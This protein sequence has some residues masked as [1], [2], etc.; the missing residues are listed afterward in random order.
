[1]HRLLTLT[2]PD[3]LPRR[4][5]YIISDIEKALA[6]E[7]ISDTID[8]QKID[9]HFIVLGRID[10]PLIAFLKDRGM[11][12]YPVPF[13]GKADL[14]RVWITVFSILKKLKPHA[15][16]THLYFAN[17]IGL[18]AAWVLRIPKRIHTRH[19]GALHHR[20]FPR[21][22]YI[23]KVVNA[24]SSHIIV[25]CLNQQTIVTGWE[26]AKKEKVFLIEHGIDLPY[27]QKEEPDKVSLLRHSHKL[28]DGRFPIVCVIARYTEWKGIQF[29]IPAFK[30]LLAAHPMAHL[31]LCNARGDYA[32]H[33]KAL[34]RTLPD[35]CYTE[36][37]FEPELASLYRL[38]DVFVHAPIDEY[39]EAFGQVYIEAL[40]SGIPSIFTLSGIACDFVR[41][42][43][44][45]WVVPHKNADEIATAM[46][47]LL[48]DPSLRARLIQSGRRRVSERFDIREMIGKLEALY[49]A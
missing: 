17:L 11:P 45:A 10:T 49:T 47:A 8:K 46:G 30:T 1:M 40:A 3:V 4:I 35:G 33:I 6:F 16:H 31:V 23:D 19:H 12:H 26:G 27:F 29:I 34:L 43:E 37:P 2:N 18:S 13:A 9:L 38:F 20:Y 28:P 25:P 22:V 42:H 41:H 44:D 5:V 32:G 15:V 7:W 24:L 48:N 14:L 21:S 36:I 39:A